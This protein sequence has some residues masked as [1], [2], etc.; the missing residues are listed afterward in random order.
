MTVQ[1]SIEQQFTLE[2]IVLLFNELSPEDKAKAYKV[3][4][5]HYLNQQNCINELMR[6]KLIGN[7][8]FMPS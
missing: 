2:K 6:E 7:E 4:V 1:L 5:F 8:S 3:L